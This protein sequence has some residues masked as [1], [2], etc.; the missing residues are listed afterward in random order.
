MAKKNMWK[1]YDFGGKHTHADVCIDWKFVGR[2]V[3]RCDW[4]GDIITQFLRISVNLEGTCLSHVRYPNLEKENFQYSGDRNLAVF[5]LGN[6]FL[7]RNL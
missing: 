2:D 7:S 3:D 5:F 4:D 6:F 1:R